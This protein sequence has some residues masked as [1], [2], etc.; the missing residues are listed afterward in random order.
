MMIELVEVARQACV[1]MT[2]FQESWLQMQTVFRCP[3][4]AAVVNEVGDEMREVRCVLLDG[5][6][7]VHVVEW[8]N[9]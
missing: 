8:G 1:A 9:L 5:H 3:E 6:E 2:E 7:G 4:L